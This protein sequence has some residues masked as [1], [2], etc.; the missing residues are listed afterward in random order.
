M[1]LIAATATAAKRLV[2]RLG[3]HDSGGAGV[4]EAIAERKTAA[5]EQASGC[6]LCKGTGDNLSG[7]MMAMNNHICPRCG[8]YG[9]LSSDP[10][11]GQ[12]YAT[13]KDFEYAAT[14]GI[15]PA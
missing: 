2:Q 11:G 7:I 4:M 10:S 1:R 5:V 13:G 8:G 3:Q 14:N 15:L 6:R 12:P 9:F